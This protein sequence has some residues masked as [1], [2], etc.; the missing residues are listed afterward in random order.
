MTCLHTFGWCSC[1]TRQEAE[2]DAQYDRYDEPPLVIRVLDGDPCDCSPRD[3]I[4]HLDGC[5]VLLDAM[6]PDERRERAVEDADD[7]R[8]DQDWGW[9]G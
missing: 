1:P 9:E 5:P 4:W 3:D 7:A 6:T 8:A 2:H